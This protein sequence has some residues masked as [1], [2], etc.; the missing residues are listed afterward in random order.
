M[1]EQKNKDFI[2]RYASALDGKPKPA[3][4]V[5]EFVTDQELADH[6]AIFEAAFPSYAFLIEDLIAEGDKVV[7]RGTFQGV[8][9]G[10]LMGIPPT[11]KEARISLMLVYRIA[12]EKIVEHW[13]NA[14][15]FSL[16]QQIG[17]IPARAEVA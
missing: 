15:T 5:A 17:A 2:R 14:D 16:L 7:L 6:I 10:E 12:G 9:K 11:G 13:M 8:H 3:E 4:V 1:S